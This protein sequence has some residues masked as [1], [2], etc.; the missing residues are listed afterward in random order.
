MDSM[1]DELIIQIYRNNTMLICLKAYI[2]FFHLFHGFDYHGMGEM[3]VA[4]S[5]ISMF[6]IRPN[7]PSA[8]FFKYNTALGPPYNVLVDTNFINFSIQ[9]KLDLEKG[10][11]DC[12]YA[13]CTPC[14]TDCVMAELEKLG[15]K[16]RVALRIA[17][18]PRFERLPCV[19]KGT[20]ADDCL[21]ERVT[22]HRCYIVATCDRDLKRRI[23]KI[24]GVPIMYITQHKYSIERLP[25][26]TI[27]GAY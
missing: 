21:V 20:Y 10:M 8:L 12:L 26:A 27:G 23:R 3:I 14:I 11:M 19:H 6:T 18:D 4:N 5:Y 7:V 22:Q 15:D 1:T 17:K 2:N 24:P 16:Y 25:E 9:N 13:K